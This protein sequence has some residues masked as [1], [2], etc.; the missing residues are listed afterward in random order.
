MRKFIRNRLLAGALA[1]CSLVSTWGLVHAEDR[2]QL[3]QLNLAR[4]RVEATQ[5][6]HIDHLAQDVVIPA[7][8]S[9]EGTIGMFYGTYAGAKNSDPQKDFYFFEV[10]QNRA[11]YEAHKAGA[12]FQTYIEA[13]KGLVKE[14]SIDMATPVLVKLRLDK[15]A[16]AMDLAIFTVQD[17]NQVQDLLNYQEEE[18]K[19]LYKNHAGIIGTMVALDQEKPRVYVWTLYE[20][21]EAYQEVLG[22][23]Q[24]TDLQRPESMPSQ[25]EVIPMEVRGDGAIFTHEFVRKYRGDS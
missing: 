25:I 4:V 2:S 19:R 7:S 3:V 21:Q 14:K 9:E 23:R 5:A 17:S 12:A 11:A 22:A 10:Y 20:N 1:F 24:L 8:Q 18:A 16:K 13:S 15:P 6:S